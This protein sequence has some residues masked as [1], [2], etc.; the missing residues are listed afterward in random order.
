MSTYL[1]TNI[2][3]YYR[4]HFNQL[5]SYVKYILI[6]L[7]VDILNHYDIILGMKNIKDTTHT[8]RLQRTLYFAYG[9]NTNHDEMASRCHDS[10]ILGA[11]RLDNHKLTFQGVADFTEQKGFALH[12]AL[13]LISQRDE[14]ALDSLEGYPHLYGKK[15]VSVHW[16]NSMVNVMIYQMQVR[17]NY[18]S[19][20]AYYEQCLMTG[21][22]Q[23]GINQKQIQK[24]KAFSIANGK[25]VVTK[26]M[27]RYYETN[28]ESEYN[29]TDE[30]DFDEPIY[31]PTQVRMGWK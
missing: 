12:G 24:A 1:F 21:Y 7:L 17:D 30:L 22:L 20:S 3:L 18:S 26:V 13:W 2:H 25:P 5:Y 23:S 14:K 31:I 8:G 9:M 4:D 28:L 16:Q 29:D 10:L 19:P 11:A 6:Y 27:K 15:T